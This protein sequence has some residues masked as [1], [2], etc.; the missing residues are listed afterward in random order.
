MKLHF[1]KQTIYTYLKHLTVINVAINE[2]NL[3]V[4]LHIITG[5]VCRTHRY[6]PNYSFVFCDRLRRNKFFD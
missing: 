6:A 4:R 5:D 1:Q 3:F 2:D